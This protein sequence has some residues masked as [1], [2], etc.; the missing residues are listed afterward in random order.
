MSTSRRQFI[1]QSALLS[2]AFLMNTEDFFKKNRN[3]GLQ[4]YTLRNEMFKD[5]KGTLQKVAALGFKE[6]ET[7]GYNEGKWFGM[8]A[9]EFSTTLSQ[10]GLTSPSGHT[11][12][13]SMFLKE[14]WEDKWKKAVD[15]SRAIGQDYIVIPWLEEPYRKPI[16]NFKKIAEGLNKA[17]VIA[18]SA[19][20]TVA[21]H[22]HD[23]EFLDQNGQTG[24]D[25][26]MKETDVSMVKL[27]LDLYWAVKAGHDPVELI[28]AHPGRFAMWH[29]KDMDKT[30][31]KFFT[32][33][34]NGSIDFKPIFAKA[35]KSGM[36]HFYVEQDFCPG[37]PLE[38]IAK[39][40]DFM[41][42]NLIK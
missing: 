33:V 9:S 5:P 19:G 15:D 12:P 28:K 18:K 31:K 42:K 6:V 20:S 7:F 13:G 21:Y 14:G 32:E 11:F 27:E 3:I 30:D 35:K 17:A 2:A 25:I 22:N 16:D 29:I 40:I 34:G 36:K 23:F 8:T 37:P 10:N 1:Q 41:K 26:L 38:S 4:L 39:S 24:F